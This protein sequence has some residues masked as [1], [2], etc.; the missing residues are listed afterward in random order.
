MT[1]IIPTFPVRLDHLPPYALH[2]LYTM[3]LDNPVA[4]VSIEVDPEFQKAPLV[5]HYIHLFHHYTRSHIDLS[6]AIAL[7]PTSVQRQMDR[8]TVKRFET[9]QLLLS[10]EFG[11]F[12]PGN[13]PSKLLG[14]LLQTTLSLLQPSELD[15]YLIPDE[16]SSTE[17]STQSSTGLGSPPSS[18]LP[19]TSSSLPSRNLAG[20]GQRLSDFISSLS[21]PS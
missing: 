11:W 16:L 6:V 15:H 21:Q 8:L 17:S 5:H 3:V 12:F 19:P 20:F 18:P 9:L 13:V 2:A 1:S 4:M 14:S 7:S 10:V